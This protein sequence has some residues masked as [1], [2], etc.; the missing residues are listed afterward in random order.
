MIP[1]KSLKSQEEL[2]KRYLRYAGIDPDISVEELR[3]MDTHTLY[4][5]APRVLLP[6]DM[7]YDSDLIPYRSVR[8]LFDHVLE[9]VDFINGADDGEAEVFAESVSG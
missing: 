8:V 1:F 4:K 7:V 5:D 2:G 6:G 9:N 3:N